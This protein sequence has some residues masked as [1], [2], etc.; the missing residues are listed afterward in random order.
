MDR[1]EESLNFI[2]RNEGIRLRAY[3]DSANIPTIGVG[4]R[5]YPNGRKVSMGDLC[6]LLDAKL[7]LQDHLTKYVFPILKAY[8]DLPDSVYVSIVDFIYNV[9]HLGPS[10]VKALND[11]N[12]IELANAMREYNEAG[13]KVVEGLVNRREAE[14]K[15]M[16][17]AG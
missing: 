4:T 9:G 12:W 16:V 2:M 14:I 17:G 10:V 5:F 13:G 3:L 15:Y 7:W 8:N 11:K 6:T 1:I